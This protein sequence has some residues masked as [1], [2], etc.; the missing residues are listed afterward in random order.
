MTPFV[1]SLPDRS[2]QSPVGK[3]SNIGRVQDTLLPIIFCFEFL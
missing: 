1:I 3:T 2:I